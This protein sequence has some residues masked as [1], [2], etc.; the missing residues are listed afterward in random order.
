[1]PVDDIVKRVLVLGVGTEIAKAD[2]SKAYRIVPVHPKD[3][4]LMGRE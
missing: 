1:M 2:V 3:R 4:W